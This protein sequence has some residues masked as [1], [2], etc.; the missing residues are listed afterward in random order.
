M[1]V[2]IAVLAPM[3]SASDRMATMEKS[4]LRTRPRSASR[5]SWAGSVMGGWTVPAGAGLAAHSMGR[6]LQP[7][8]MALP[9]GQSVKWR[10]VGCKVRPSQASAG[11]PGLQ[12][13]RR[14]FAG[15]F[16]TAACQASSMALR[17]AASF[18][19]ARCTVV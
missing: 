3:P 9:L 14:V 12:P 2:K 16:A 13:R 19:G 5:K 7:T 6:T 11:A 10:R 17:T 4:G 15:G 18:A 8:A 1:R